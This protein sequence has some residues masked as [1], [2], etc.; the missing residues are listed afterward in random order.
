LPLL[1][2]E[3]H[4]P[5]LFNRADY[6]AL[7]GVV[8]V[9]P[10][11]G[12]CPPRGRVVEAVGHDREPSLCA[13]YPPC[14]LRNSCWCDSTGSPWRPGSL[15]DEGPRLLGPIS[16][17]PPG[18]RTGCFR[19]KAITVRPGRARPG[20]REMSQMRRTNFDKLLGWI[21]TGLGVALLTVHGH[22]PVGQVLGGGLARTA[23]A[24]LDQTPG[25]ITGILTS[26]TWKRHARSRPAT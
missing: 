11:V 17:N 5:G 19:R 21:G 24:H 7:H 15:D 23:R 4:S 9:I 10:H 26:T 14:A 13:P 12:Y 6:A 2:R 22:P 8:P 3:D 25:M 20:I 1:V 18:G 16:H